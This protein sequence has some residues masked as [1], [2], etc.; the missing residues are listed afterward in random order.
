MGPF[1]G[2]GA[3]RRERGGSRGV[4]GAAV[5]VHGPFSCAALLPVAPPAAGDGAGG[6]AQQLVPVPVSQRVGECH[7]PV[8]AQGDVAG[9]L[10]SHWGRETA[11]AGAL[12]PMGLLGC[13]P[14]CVGQS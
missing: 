14:S 3:S 4:A 11:E 1:A 7:A 13:V 5:C 9:V 12:R 2:T 6:C 10:Q 8:S